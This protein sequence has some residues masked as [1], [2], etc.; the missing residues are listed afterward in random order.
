M[1]DAHTILF[2]LMVNF[3]LGQNSCVYPDDPQNWTRE[4]FIK[5]EKSSVSAYLYKFGENEQITDSLLLCRM[6][7][8]TIENKILGEW[9]GYEYGHNYRYFEIYYNGM[10]QIVKYKTLPISGIDGNS[11]THQREIDYEY[12]SL[13]RKIKQTCKIIRKYY[14]KPKHNKDSTLVLLHIEGPY[15][16]EYVYNSDNQKIEFYKT[17]DTTKEIKYTKSKRKL[18]KIFNYSYYRPK[19][20]VS[21][22]KYDSLS[23]VTE[24]TFFVDDNLIQHKRNY[25]YDEQN[26][27]IKQVDSTDLTTTEPCVSRT[28]T[29]EYTDTGKIKTIMHYFKNGVSKSTSYYSNG[30]YEKHCYSN[31][32]E[33]EV[34]TEHFYSYENNKFT[35]TI[36]NHDSGSVYTVTYLYNEKGLLIEQQ[37]INNNKTAEFTRYHYE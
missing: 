9:H 5:N 2:I 13:N 34:C 1:K 36:T 20:L 4:D 29:Y 37:A 27:I 7:F 24:E 15:I 21:K 33:E 18:K 23:N 17:C 25:F 10:G 12:D 22:W 26:R 19:Q 31:T 8:D 32:P 35:K 11:V 16:E 28:T 14:F 3:A 30:E 6:Q